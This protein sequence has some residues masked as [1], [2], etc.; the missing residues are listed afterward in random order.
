MLWKYV[1]TFLASEASL[2]PLQRTGESGG[3]EKPL[4]KC[5]IL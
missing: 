5:D 4:T 2:N 3:Y 1:L